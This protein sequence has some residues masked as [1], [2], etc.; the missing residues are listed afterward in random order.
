MID[1]TYQFIMKAPAQRLSLAISWL[2]VSSEAMFLWTRE[3]Q[4]SMILKMNVRSENK[5]MIAQNS[6]E[7]VWQGVL[8]TNFDNPNVRI[9]KLDKFVLI[10]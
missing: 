2:V 5:A 1:G 4:I 3:S 6:H 7:I 8:S 10:F 9:S